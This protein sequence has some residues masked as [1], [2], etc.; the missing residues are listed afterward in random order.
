MR[1]EEIQRKSRRTPP[2]PARAAGRR[3][4]WRRT[5]SGAAGDPRPG[6]LRV[7]FLENGLRIN[8]PRRQTDFGEITGLVDLESVSTIE[9]VRGPASVLYGSDAIGGVLNLISADPLFAPGPDIRLRRPSLVPAVSAGAAPAS[10]RLASAAHAAA[11]RDEPSRRRL[12]RPPGLR[13][14]PTRTPR[15]S[16]TPASTT[17]TSG[18]ARLAL[19]DRDMLRFRFNHYRPTIPGSASS[20]EPVRRDRR[21]QDPHLLSDQNFDRFML[22]YFGSPLG[23]AGRLHECTGLLSAQQAE[24]GQ[25]HPHRHRTGRS[26]IPEFQRGREYAQLH[27]SPNVGRACGRG[28]GAPGR[29]AHRHLRLRGFPRRQLQHRFLPHGH[30]DS[31]SAR[32]VPSTSTDTIA[33]APNATNTS[34]GVFVQDEWTHRPASV[35]PAV[36]AITGQDESRADSRLERRWPRFLRPQ[37]R[38]RTHG[39][40]SDD[41]L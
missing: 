39:H 34:Y 1:E 3:R 24:A 33:N 8:N 27:R 37:R 25:R 31:H 20:P 6:G 40:L 19:N 23:H 18:A 21:R 29:P 30:D 26:G 13:R 2:T 32:R 16:S 36:C 12:Q 15:R 10:E 22:S 35:S 5:E 41:R 14:D 7:L 28:E 11:R 38:R 9:V 17:R 4:Q